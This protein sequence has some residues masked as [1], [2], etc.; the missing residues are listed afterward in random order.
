MGGRRRRARGGRRYWRSCWV[1]LLGE[2]QGL[3]VLGCVGR[4]AGDYLTCTCV[5][6]VNGGKGRGILTQLRWPVTRPLAC[7][8]TC[9]YTSALVG[10]WEVEK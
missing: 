6:N 9:A 8:R 2:D 10:S 4:E 7:S 5:S 1:E 3:Y